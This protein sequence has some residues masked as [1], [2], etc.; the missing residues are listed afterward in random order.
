MTLPIFLFSNGCC[1]KFQGANSQEVK[2]GNLD[3][4]AKLLLSAA[5]LDIAAM[6][7]FFVIGILVALSLIGIPAV[8]GYVF[9]SVS[10]VLLGSWIASAVI[11]KG[12]SLF[13]VS[14]LFQGAFKVC[15]LHT[16]AA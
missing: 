4:A 14:E 13:I 16:E 3:F 15:F 7:S 11:S 6:I 8:A 9:I 5:L 2:K 12:T 1:G 10:A